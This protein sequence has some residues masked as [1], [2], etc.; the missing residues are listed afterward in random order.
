M[1]EENR[2]L[3]QGEIFQLMKLKG[4]ERGADVEFL[5]NY[6]KRKEGKNGYKEFE[7]V[8]SNFGFDMFDVE[9]TSATEW[10]PEFI[11]HVLL[12]GAF[13]FFD[14]TEKDVFEM[15]RDALSLSKT[16]K[17]FIK[18]F[19]SAK[20]TITKMA[21]DWNKYYTYGK[22]SIRNFDKDKKRALFFI[23]DFKTHPLT[24]VYL[25][26]IAFGVLELATGSKNVKVVE[27]K[28]MFKGD[29]HHEFKLSW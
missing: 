2:Q 5:V 17:I 28:C 22:A 11:P 10:I 21:K 19:S 7:K 23:E 26:G 29:N 24:C 16:L 4:M 9:K 3:L 14:W 27:E 18:W 20:I 25:S 8:L 1:T 13:R 6:I 12:V 15:G